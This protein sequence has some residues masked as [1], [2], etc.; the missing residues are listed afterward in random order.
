MEDEELSEPAEVGA[1][2]RA[3]STLLQPSGVRT[4]TGSK[5][6]TFVF[7]AACG[8][9]PTKQVIAQVPATIAPRLTEDIVHIEP[10]ARA[11]LQSLAAGGGSWGG[12]GGG[13]AFPTFDSKGPSKYAKKTAGRVKAPAG[14]H[15]T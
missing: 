15:G 14:S 6:G 2:R 7:S 13:L 8:L 5:A 9:S 1:D 3:A 4:P 10:G 11:L 12:G